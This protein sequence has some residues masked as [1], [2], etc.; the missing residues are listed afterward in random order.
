MQTK[1][2]TIGAQ[3]TAMNRRRVLSSAAAEREE[4]VGG[5]LD[6]EPAQELRGDLALEHDAVDLVGARMR[7]EHGE[8]IDEERRREQCGH[9]RA[10]AARPP[11]P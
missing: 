9:R 8:G 10:R 2:L 1:L 7:I 5:D 4:A 3:A 11:T 6:H